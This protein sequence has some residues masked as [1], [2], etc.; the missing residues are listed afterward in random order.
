[1][2]KTVI[3]WPGCHTTWALDRERIAL[4]AGLHWFSDQTIRQVFLSKSPYSCQDFFW[5]LLPQVGLFS[6]VAGPA[7][8]DVF[9]AMGGGFVPSG[10]HS[11][12]SKK[13]V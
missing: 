9:L 13:N 4:A 6:P 1:V 5:S 7:I 12:P 8:L 2:K 3:A 10:T 11:L